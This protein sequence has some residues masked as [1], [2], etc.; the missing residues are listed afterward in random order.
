MRGLLI[1]LVVLSFFVLAC[2]AFGQ[3][4]NGVCNQMPSTVYYSPTPIQEPTL[5]LPLPGYDEPAPKVVYWDR[6]VLT[7][8]T[9]YYDQPQYRVTNYDRG[10]RLLAGQP[11]RNL[12][13]RLFRPRSWRLFSRWSD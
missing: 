9:I 3:C 12:F 7:R 5:A 2:D 8:R 1:L 10:P 13:R 11:M 4:R 6:S